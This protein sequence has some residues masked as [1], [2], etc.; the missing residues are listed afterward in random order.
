MPTPEVNR[1]MTA[2]LSELYERH[3]IFGDQPASY[4]PPEMEAEKHRLGMAI[5]HVDG[6]QFHI[7]DAEYRFPLHSISKVFTY[8]Q[9]LEDR[10]RDAV[11]SRVGV[12][13]SGDPFNSITFD[14]ANNRPFNPMINAGALVA[15]NLVHGSDREEKV[16][17]I[18]ERLRIYA[19][20]P[21]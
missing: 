19:A 9:A 6:T 10:G 21:D 11:L 17:R 5:T 15:A 3:L 8:A 2:Q 20:N 12:E 13:P 18:L 7:G 1:I 16:G 14:E 4:Y